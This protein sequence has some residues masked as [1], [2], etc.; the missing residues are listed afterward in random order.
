MEFEKTGAEAIKVLQFLKDSELKP[1]EKIAVLEAASSIIRAT[2]ASEGFRMAW[3][4]IIS[5][6]PKK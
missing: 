5:G 6:S 4:N 1:D 2:V 3:I